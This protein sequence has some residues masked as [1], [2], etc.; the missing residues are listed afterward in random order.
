[1]PGSALV[2]ADVSDVD[3]ADDG[4]VVVPSDH[5]TEYIGALTTFRDHSQALRWLV[6]RVA[7]DLCGRAALIDLSGSQ[8]RT[9]VGELGDAHVPLPDAAV[10]ARRRAG[11]SPVATVTSNGRVLHM[12]PVGD[13]K[14]ETMLVVADTVRPFREIWPTIARAAG[15]IGVYAR[16]QRAEHAE[17]RLGDVGSRLTDAVRHLLCAGNTGAAHQVA[18]AMGRTLPDPVRLAVLEGLPRQSRERFHRNPEVLGKSIWAFRATAQ[19][20]AIMLL[21]AEEDREDLEALVARIS[22]AGGCRV[23]I[24]DVVA[25][26]ETGSGYEQAL[27]ALYATPVGSGGGPER[28]E[29]RTKLTHV[30]GPAARGWAYNL[31]RPLLTYEPPRRG[32]PDADELVRTARV[33][34]RL[35]QYASR[36]LDIHRNTARERLRQIGELVGADLNRVADQAVLALALR[37]YELWPDDGALTAPVVGLEELL[38]MPEAVNW[39]RRQLKPLFWQESDMALETVRTW[40]ANDA[41]V[42]GTALQL[43]VS[44]TAVRKRLMRL[45]RDL[46]RSLLELPG[47]RHD[48]WLALLVHDRALARESGSAGPPVPRVPRD[49]VPDGPSNVSVS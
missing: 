37:I 34:L 20:A 16:A 7:E 45:S 23:G 10:A 19:H 42:A 31:L 40:L 49:L 48:L 22:A 28:F 25:L 21:A 35:A 18:A 6:R 4:S 2:C 13:G 41:S 32:A 14:P 5:D 8:P 12:V 24:S 46:E 1:M 3:R 38:D 27:H 44:A 39:A 15:L 47:T 30:L 11:G 26:R 17:Q 43:G 36:D 29:S 9:V 33:W